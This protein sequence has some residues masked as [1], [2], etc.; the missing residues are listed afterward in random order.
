MSKKPKVLILGATGLF[1][2]LLA[3]RLIKIDRF[4]V[5][6]AG[7]TE[8]SL[9]KF[10]DEFGGRFRVFDRGD[11]K[12]TGAV[13]HELKPFAVVD[14]A[15]PFQYYGDDPY[16]FARQVI[17]VGAHYLDIADAPEFVAGIGELDALAKER[18]VVAISGASS[19]PGI[20][21]AV[22]D[23]L[24]HD[25]K[26]IDSIETA[27]IPGNKARRTISV[28]QAVLGQVGQVFAVQRNGRIETVRGWSAMKRVDLAVPVKRP[29]RNGHAYLMNTPDVAL[30]P[31]RYGAK[32]VL[33]RAGLEIKAFCYA[34]VVGGWLVRAGLVKS[35][36]P[37]A[38]LVRWLAGWFEW[39]GSD[40]GGMQ[41]DVVGQTKDGSRER[42]IWNVI[43]S[44]GRGPEIPTLPVSILLVKLVKGKIEAGARPSPG[45]I[46]RDEVEAALSGIDAGAGVQVKS[47]D[48]VFKQALGL[49]FDELPEPIRELHNNF[50]EVVYEGRAKTKGATGLLGRIGAMVVGFPSNSENIPV[51]VTITA[52]ENGE[53]WKREFDG[54]PFV[55]RLSVDEKGYAQE[56][57]GSLAMRLGLHLKDEKLHYPVICGRLFGWIPFPSILMPQSISH[58]E[59]DEEGRFAFDVLLKFRFG[60]RI[61]HYRGWLVK[62]DL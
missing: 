45:E 21:A 25:M 41:V 16:R 17:D 50:G 18:G 53:T 35:L 22:V 44:S 9:Q 32:T 3:R 59:V 4:D 12:G 13:L 15:G 11:E 28:M 49:A 56:R 38:K 19:T 43:A 34:L 42:R 36:L 57:F 8:K 33:F 24:T 60:G 29:I 26:E 54:K 14:C 46:T 20:S 7:R 58:E 30:F 1:G 31:E 27:I 23:A 6:C 62:R 55:S 51:K 52:D 39:A 48:P 10:C 47:V 2:G 37:F 40:A 5:I 61:A